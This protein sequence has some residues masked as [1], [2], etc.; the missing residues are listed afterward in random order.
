M[1]KLSA[2]T[3]LITSESPQEEA[4]HEIYNVIDRYEKKLLTFS[5]LRIRVQNQFPVGGNMNWKYFGSIEIFKEMQKMTASILRM[6]LAHYYFSDR[7]AFDLMM[8]AFYGLKQPLDEKGEPS[9]KDILIDCKFPLHARAFEILDAIYEVD[10]EDASM[11]LEIDYRHYL[12]LEA[13]KN[14]SLDETEKLLE[15]NMKRKCGWQ[16]YVWRRDAQPMELFAIAHLAEA[17]K[18]LS[19]PACFVLM[20]KRWMGNPE[21]RY[22]MRRKTALNF[23]NLRRDHLEENGNWN[24]A[25]FSL[26]ILVY[27]FAVQL[28]QILYVITFFL[29]R[30]NFGQVYSSK[31]FPGEKNYGNATKE[32][33]K[34]NNFFRL[35]LNALSIASLMYLPTSLSSGIE[36]EEEYAH[37]ETKAAMRLYFFATVFC[38]C[39]LQLSFV[40]E[41]LSF[42]SYFDVFRFFGFFTVIMQRMFVIFG[43]FFLLF[44]S[45]WSILGVLYVS[46]TSFAK[47]ND[48]L[49]FR[50]F[51]AGAF[52]I[53][54]EAKE[55]DISGSTSGCDPVYLRDMSTMRLEQIRCFIRSTL[56]PVI[57]F[58]YMFVASIFLMNLFTAQLTKEYEEACEETCFNYKYYG[59]LAKYESKLRLPPPFSLFYYFARFTGQL[60]LVRFFEGHPWGSLN[61]VLKNHDKEDERILK[62]IRKL[63]ALESLPAD[64]DLN[65]VNRIKM[66]RRVV[67][68]SIY[69]YENEILSPAQKSLERSLQTMVNE[70]PTSSSSEKHKESYKNFA[71]VVEKAIDDWRLATK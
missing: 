20:K 7:S 25:K 24:W 29:D 27:A 55:G 56:I 14:V 64:G 50:F 12:Y 57:M 65:S 38:E 19:H 51:Q 30:L 34:N 68:E 44:V 59:Q 63:L 40:V 69:E 48:T 6:E 33:T 54:G 42:L 18:F 13:K 66:V 8:A 47:T 52:E 26:G 61:Q 41:T 43:K 70:A 46:N 17:T 49:M 4:T 23:L 3:P 39:I 28:C 37:K 21:G 1:S 32:Y 35:F 60:Y 58:S 67:E 62:R 5:K 31:E 53:F 71:L 11:A 45:L 9:T 10:P 22:A 16:N 36:S 2:S 15:K